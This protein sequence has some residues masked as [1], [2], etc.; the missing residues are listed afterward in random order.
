MAMRLV[1]DTN[2]YS[3]LMKGDARVREIM[4]ASEWLG[5]PSI[6]VGELTAGFLAGGKA[7]SNLSLLDSFIEEAGIEVLAIG[8]REAERYGAVV[9]ALRERGTPIP[10]N[11]VW[12]AAQTL[13]ADA[14]LLSRDRHFDLVPGLIRME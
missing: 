13:V 11:D 4:E 3:A 1:L 5:L 2:A 7:A 9:K 8:R 6:V 14:R 12:I 10:T